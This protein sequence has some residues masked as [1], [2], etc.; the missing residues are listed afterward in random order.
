[1]TSQKTLLATAVGVYL[2]GFGL[3]VGTVIG[4]MRFDAKRTAVLTRY[5]QALHQVKTPVSVHFRD[6]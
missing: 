6:F 5:E 2:L 3:L 1:M 4:R